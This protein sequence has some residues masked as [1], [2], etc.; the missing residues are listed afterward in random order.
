MFRF[1]IRDLLWLMVVVGIA[2]AWIDRERTW[3][4]SLGRTYQELLESE[5]RKL[6]REMSEELD[7]HI[8]CLLYTSDAA[9]E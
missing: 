6:R 2:L 1:T 8:G 9:D 7:L 5:R 3:R 4:A